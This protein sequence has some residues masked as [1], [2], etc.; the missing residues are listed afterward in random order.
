MNKFGER[1]KST[2]FGFQNNPFSTFWA[3]DF[4]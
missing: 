4:P 3:K 2:D 1:F